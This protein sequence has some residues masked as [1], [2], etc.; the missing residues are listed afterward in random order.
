M[1]YIIPV[2]PKTLTFIVMRVTSKSGQS[3]VKVDKFEMSNG[4]DLAELF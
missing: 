4:S 1:R 2:M 3:V